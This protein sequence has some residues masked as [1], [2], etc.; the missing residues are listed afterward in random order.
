MNPM[1]SLQILLLLLVLSPLGLTAQN[2]S[3]SESVDYLNDHL[4]D[5]DLIDEEWELIEYDEKNN[6]L[7][8]ESYIGFGDVMITTLYLDGN[9]WHEEY[10]DEEYG[11]V[12]VVNF[13]NNDVVQ[14]DFF[15]EYYTNQFYFAN[16]SAKNTKVLLDLLDLIHDRSK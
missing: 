13:E 15:G 2:L 1:K 12:M 5:F 14:L 11:D 6:A 7:L 3:I 9:F 16:Y 4:R 8:I 10:R